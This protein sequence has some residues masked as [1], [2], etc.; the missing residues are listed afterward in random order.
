MIYYGKYRKWSEVRDIG[1]VKCVVGCMGYD[2]NF[3]L[4]WEVWGVVGN[5]E[6]IGNYGI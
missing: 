2:G 3:G 4:G 1:E 5:T 6:Y